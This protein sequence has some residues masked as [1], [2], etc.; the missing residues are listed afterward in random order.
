MKVYEIITDKIIKKLEEG[1]IAWNKAWK[2]TRPQNF[3]TKK[4]YRG[5]NIILLTLAGFSCPYWASFKQI[6]ELGGQVK[7]GSK[8][9]MIIYWKIL[10]YKNKN[11]KDEDITKKIPLLRYYRVFNLEQTRGIKYEIEK[12]VFNPIQEC[13]K[14]IEGYTSKPEIKYNEPQAYYSPKL[15]YINMPKKELFKSDEGYYATLFH[16][17]N[18]STG[19][20]GKLDR[21]SVV[22]AGYYGSEN[23]SKEEL[24]A[25]LGASFLCGITGIENKTIDNSASYIKGWLKALKNDKKMIIYASAQA[26]KSVDYIL[27]GNMHRKTLTIHVHFKEKKVAEQTKTL[28]KVS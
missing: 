3:K 28:V 6:N 12:R 4:E 9:S 27:K 5:I 25:E 2:T 19:A 20:R 23:Y 1:T 21:K 26:Q 8:S 18:H 16:E 22:D 11:D 14:V 10:E 7:K 24:V 17:F 15:D 13:E